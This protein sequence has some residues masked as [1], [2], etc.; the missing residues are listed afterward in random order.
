MPWRPPA[1][2]SLGDE[3]AD[4]AGRAWRFEGPWNRL[5]F[6]GAPTAAGP[7]W[8]L[9]LLTRDRAPCSHADAEAVAASTATGSHQG[10]VRQWT[11][12]TD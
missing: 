9:I 12:L 6:D 5:A 2:L 7:E 11:S 3:V 8:P 1:A 4:T 10:T